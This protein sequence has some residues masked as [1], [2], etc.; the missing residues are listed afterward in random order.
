MQITVNQKEF[1]PAFAWAYGGLPKR[2][3]VPV[4]SG[5]RLAVEGRTLTLSAFDYEQSR[6]RRLNGDN[7]GAGQ[8]L[9]DGPELK[10]IVSS[11]PKGERVTVDISADS[12]ALTLASQGI[13]WRLPALPD[14]DYPALP[15]LPRLA[16]VADG[17]EFAR[18]IGRVV[19]A[20]SR[21]DTL[22]VLTCI[23]FETHA[24]AVALAATDRYR[25][26]LDRISW[27]PADPQAPVTR[28][29]VPADAAEVFAKKAGGKVAIHLSAGMAGFSDDAR[30]L[31]IRTR[32]GDFVRYRPLLRTESPV[33]LTADAKALAAA[34]ERMGEISGKTPAGHTPVAL[35]Y[36]GNAVTVQALT[37]D[38]EVRASETLP[39]GA[40]GATE[41]EV[42]FNSA[43][44]ASMLRG[45]NGKAVIG[46]A[47]D[48]PRAQKAATINAAAADTFTALVVPYRRDPVRQIRTRH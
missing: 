21:D 7:A 29:N 46:L 14:E 19:P 34:A 35:V 44:L 28:A 9:V 10:K 16:G 36:A 5:M 12:S 22:P 2:A 39:A 31:T 13:T 33:T 8:V 6:R 3:A 43:Y 48:L 45:I 20:A 26:A 17:E 40:E 25:L 41:F 23:L 37:L 4:L 38:D 11:L 15:A 24:A 27:T 42:R 32:P 1:A 30:E 18:A 47:G